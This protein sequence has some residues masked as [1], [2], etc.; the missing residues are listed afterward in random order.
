[1]GCRFIIYQRNTLLSE[2]RCVVS[3]STL[4][5]CLRKN[6]S[7]MGVC[8]MD[9]YSTK[10]LNPRSPYTL[11]LIFILLTLG[12]EEEVEEQLDEIRLLVLNTK[13]SLESARVNAENFH[14]SM[15][16]LQARLNNIERV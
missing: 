12:W 15:K 2:E 5:I 10:G 8:K 16:S 13:N 4:S 1:M 9:Q 11:F 3:R 14:A 7:N 6:F